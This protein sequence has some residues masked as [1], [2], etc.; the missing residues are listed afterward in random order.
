MSGGLQ[1][2]GDYSKW[3]VKN[4]RRLLKSGWLNVRGGYR[5]VRG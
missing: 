1:I 5:R 3:R 4:E 2:R